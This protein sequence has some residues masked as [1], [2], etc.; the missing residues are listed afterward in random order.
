MIR[1]S[2]PSAYQGRRGRQW[3]WKHL[4]EAGEARDAFSRIFMTSAKNLTRMQNFDPPTMP[5]CSQLTEKYQFEKF[6]WKN[7]T[8]VR[9]ATTG[10]KHSRPSWNWSKK[11]FLSK[12]SK[13]PNFQPSKTGLIEWKLAEKRV[14]FWPFLTPPAQTPCSRGPHPGSSEVP[15]G[16][17]QI[18]PQTLSSAFPRGIC[19]PKTFPI[20]KTG[21]ILNPQ[22]FTPGPFFRQKGPMCVQT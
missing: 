20:V 17:S 10:L 13:S 2:A 16:G 19:G 21:K 11:F 3:G 18:T 6:A 7:M 9:K 1:I 15:L 8:R 22:L 14:R 12:N 4:P 5:V